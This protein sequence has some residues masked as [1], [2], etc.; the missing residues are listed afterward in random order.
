M[1]EIKAQTEEMSVEDFLRQATFILEKLQ[2]LAVDMNRL[3][4][5]QVT[6]EDWHRFNRGEKG[7]FVRKLLGFREKARLAAIRGTLSKRHTVP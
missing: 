1:L 2:S 7:V 6:E 4:E 3:L 5:T